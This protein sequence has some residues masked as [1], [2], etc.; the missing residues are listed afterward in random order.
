MTEPPT[1]GSAETDTGTSV[2]VSIVAREN[3]G[4]RRATLL[5]NTDSAQRLVEALIEA[6]CDTARVQAYSSRE[7]RVGIEFNPTVALYDNDGGVIAAA[8]AEVATPPPNTAT[9]VPIEPARPPVEPE[10][11]PVESSP[12]TAPA[13]NF[14][15]RA[16]R[17]VFA[18]LWA[19]S[20]IVLLASLAVSLS[21]S[22]PR[23]FVPTE[24]VSGTALPSPQT[25]ALDQSLSPVPGTNGGLPACFAGGVN[26]CHCADF[27]TQEDAQRFFSRHPPGAGHVVDT[28]GDGVVCEWL[29]ATTPSR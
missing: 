20:L 5:D 24:P 19:A 29:P 14:H 27:S 28:D 21:R 13:P 12:A 8:L 7:V 4:S 9:G 25:R 15:V 23:E 10:A 11:Q 22:G 18:C 16:D 26:D 6:G 3:G 1:N 17:I 2:I